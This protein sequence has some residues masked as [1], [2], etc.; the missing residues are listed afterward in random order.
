MIASLR[1]GTIALF[2]VPARRKYHQCRSRMPV[3]I[4]YMQLEA[5][6]YADDST[7]PDKP[8][9]P[10]SRSISLRHSE[11]RFRALKVTYRVLSV[12]YRLQSILVVVE[13]LETVRTI[14][15]KAQ[16]VRVTFALGE[17]CC[18]IKLQAVRCE[19][20]PRRHV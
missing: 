2:R 14:T 15:L 10:F 3:C 12:V 20:A 18:R 17:R 7:K 6:K 13:M 1:S 16:T 9:I 5:K 4:V 8:E 19:W 11:A